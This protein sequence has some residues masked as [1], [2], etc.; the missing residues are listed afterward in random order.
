MPE[1][2][3]EINRQQRMLA[4]KRYFGY[5]WTDSDE[6]KLQQRLRAVR[7]ST[8]NGTDPIRV[9]AI[10]LTVA[11]A[12][13]VA[14]ETGQPVVVDG[15]GE[16]TW[17]PTVLSVLYNSTLLLK[18]KKECCMR[19]AWELMEGCAGTFVGGNYS[20]NAQDEG[21]ATILA[22]GCTWVLEDCHIRCIAGTAVRAHDGQSANMQAYSDQGAM[23]PE[24]LGNDDLPSHVSLRRCG[25]GGDDPE[26]FERVTHSV[27]Q[28]PGAQV[29]LAQSAVDVYGSSSVECVRCSLAD[30]DNVIART[31]EK[32]SL[33]LE[34]FA[35]V[36]A[37]TCILSLERKLW[38]M[39]T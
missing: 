2:Q 4:R 10:L 36:Y 14:M 11:E 24:D 25:L 38:G 22:R 15:V 34:R 6:E 32:S 5:Q 26:R 31:F 19:G 35:P 17:E 13:E 1:V 27:S 16:H 18:S 33:K 12:V 8:R 3:Q 23:F 20:L 30:T 39:S 7:V 29:K 28:E 37:Q 9:P 21:D